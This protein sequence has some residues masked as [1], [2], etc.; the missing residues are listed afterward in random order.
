MMGQRLG[1][2]VGAEVHDDAAEERPEK[3]RE[4]IVRARG[5]GT[6]RG[7]LLMKCQAGALSG[8]SQMKILF[9]FLL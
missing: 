2:R 9:F 5:L 7:W 8:A 6:M 1:L 4:C 3:E